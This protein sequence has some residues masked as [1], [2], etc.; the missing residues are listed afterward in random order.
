MPTPN[1]RDLLRLALLAVAIGWLL[2]D[3][4]RSTTR[5]LQFVLTVLLATIVTRTVSWRTAAYALSLGM[6]LA[7]PATILAGHVLG[8]AGVSVSEGAGSWFVVPVLEEALK[9]VPVLLIAVLHRRRSG[10]SL[11]PSDWLLAGCAAGA[12][13]AMIENAALTGSSPAVL[14]DMA[15]QYGPH[16]GGLFVVPGA[17]GAAGFVGH[18]AATGIAAGSIGVALALRRQR[19]PAGSTPLARLKRIPGPWW[20][21]AA[22]ACAWVTLEHALANLYVNTGA[23]AALLLGNGRL[24]PWLFVLLVVAVVAVDAA[25]ARQTLARSAILRTRRH[26]VALAWRGDRVP[27]R[28]SRPQIVRLYLRELRT[29]NT[30]AWATFDRSAA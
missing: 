13:F 22:A 2:I 15:L 21:V 8:A 10:D 3:A 11:N 26:L 16:I 25:H 29:L 24:T 12:G 27:V 28:R 6:A 1:P 17:W 19:T 18:A 5:E 7:V 23:E 14:R 9:L 4:P 20:T 30:A